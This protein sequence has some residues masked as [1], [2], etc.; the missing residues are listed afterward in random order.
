MR[1]FIDILLFHLLDRTKKQ[2]VETV[3]DVQAEKSA[4]KVLKDVVAGKD[5]HESLIKR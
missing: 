2:E 1:Y 5:V 4:E 3:V